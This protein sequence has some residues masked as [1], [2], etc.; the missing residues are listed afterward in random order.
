MLLTRY[1]LVQSDEDESALRFVRLISDV[2]CHGNKNRSRSRRLSWNLRVGHGPS[3]QARIIP[4]RLMF[5]G[6]D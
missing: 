6:F 4:P 2:Q 3:D 5:I 1:L